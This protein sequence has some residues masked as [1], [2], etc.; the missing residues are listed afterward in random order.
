MQAHE[1]TKKGDIAKVAI[2]EAEIDK[3]A[4]QLWGLTDAELSEIQRSLKELIE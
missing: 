4:A 3:L 2:L 1:A